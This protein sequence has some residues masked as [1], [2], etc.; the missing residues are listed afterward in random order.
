MK[1]CTFPAVELFSCHSMVSLS[2]PRHPLFTHCLPV[3]EPVSGLQPS[4]GHW[5]Q[6]GQEMSIVLGV[7][8]GEIK[9]ETVKI[10]EEFIL[11]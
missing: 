3:L 5:Q 6:G 2:S 10:E 4:V 11:G 8:G 1:K 7:P 9:I